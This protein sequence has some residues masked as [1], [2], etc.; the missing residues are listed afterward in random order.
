M[1]VIFYPHK[2]LDR[3][4]ELILNQEGQ[5]LHGEIKV[6]RDLHESLGKSKKEYHVWHDIS[7]PEHIDG[8]FD[9]EN[10]NPNNKISTQIDFIVLCDE[11][12]I[13]LEVKGG[14]ISYRD[15]QFYYRKNGFET[16]CSDPYSQSNGQKHTLKNRILN[17]YK[18]F[19]SNAVAFPHLD[20]KFT[21]KIHNE[22]QLWSAYSARKYHSDS[23]E[24]FLLSW[25]KT[26]KEM[27]MA[28]GRTFRVF[29]PLQITQ[30]IRDLS[31]EVYDENPLS[32]VEDT[33]EWLEVQN[34]EILEGLQKNDR[35]M[36]EGP[37]GSGKT[38]YALAFADR[39][40]RKKGIYLCWNTLLKH[41]I[42]CKINNRKL[43]N[44]LKVFTY[45]KFI[46]DNGEFSFEELKDLNEVEY[47]KKTQIA[48]DKIKSK[49][50]FE[51]YDYIIIDEA[52]DF[53]EKGLELVLNELC[54]KNNNGLGNGNI[55][56]LYD[57]DQSYSWNGRNIREDIEYLSGFFAHYKLNE[58]KRSSQE[59]GIKKLSLNL[60][61]NLDLSLTNNNIK[62]EE[63]N[64]FKEAKSKL[65]KDYLHSIRSTSSSLIG[66][67]CV[68]LGES[69][70]Y[71]KQ[72][73]IYFPDEFIVSDMEELTIDN[74]C[75]TKNILKHTSILK[76]KGLES[77]NVFLFTKSPNSYNQYELYIGITRAINYL[78]IFIINEA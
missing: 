71:N 23:I 38:T 20:I 34:L 42:E 49:Q 15:N 50:S 17:E 8:Y 27:H 62:I 56:F 3:L 33:Y 35:I 68:V 26:E 6:Y 30:I 11:G 24:N 70:F 63:F 16:L 28:R 78:H 21:T 67:D 77:R 51:N 66:K 2:P 72:N 12:L 36:I 25:I 52:Q 13:V 45:Q 73:N 53:A 22:K 61:H 55:L 44:N 5:T 74:V 58:T 60:L 9:G 31:P 76:Y 4:E 48:I 69:M 29:T 18:G 64:T 14:H 1:S 19:F 75:N 46:Q 57:I 37:P 59:S 7:L 40:K 32:S 47:Y 54:G 10:S 39:F 65:L 41:S 43:S